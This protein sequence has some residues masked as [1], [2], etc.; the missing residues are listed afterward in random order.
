MMIT[1]LRPGQYL[2][3][4]GRNHSGWRKRTRKL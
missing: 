1:S 3:V 2:A 4:A